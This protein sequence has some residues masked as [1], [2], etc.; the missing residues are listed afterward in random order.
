[1]NKES[2]TKIITR[3]LRAGGVRTRDASDIEAMTIIPTTAENT[4]HDPDRD[5]GT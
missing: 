1:M 4:D 2:M 5:H 3:F